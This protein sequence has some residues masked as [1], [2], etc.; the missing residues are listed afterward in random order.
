MS[1]EKQNWIDHLEDA[2]TGELLQEG[3]LITAN[4]MNHIEEG[5]Y[6][7]SSQ[8]KENKTFIT[9]EMF[10]GDTDN[11]KVQNAI[12]YAIA[13][14]VLLTSKGEKVYEISNTLVINGFIKIDFNMATLKATTNS[15]ILEINTTNTSNRY[16]GYIKNITFDCNNISNCAMKLTHSQRF[17]ISNIS[18]NKIKQTGIDIV[19]G[20]V[21]KFEYIWIYNDNDNKGTTGIINRAADMV[22]SHID[23]INVERSIYHT[24]G[25]AF[26][27]EVHGFVTDKVYENSV[28]FENDGTSGVFLDRCYPDT[29]QIFYKINN[30]SKMQITNNYGFW[31][32]QFMSDTLIDSYGNPY[33][34]YFK[35][36]N[37]EFSKRIAFNN[38]VI[39]GYGTDTKMTKFSN[40]SNSLIHMNATNLY[41][42]IENLRC[43]SVG[44][45]EMKTPF[46]AT[47]NYYEMGSESFRIFIETTFNPSINGKLERTGGVDIAYMPSSYTSIYQGEY[48]FPVEYGIG[49]NQAFKSLG[50]IPGALVKGSSIIRVKA[51][52]DMYSNSEILCDAN[53]NTNYTFRISTVLPTFGY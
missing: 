13:N 11:I 14:D 39:I 6:Q 43:S 38:N 30:I 45:L 34:F 2:E 35:D 26:Y 24:G 33:V 15:P 40:L 8:I 51:P 10:N 44:T 32:K 48:S 49:N 17:H 50:F 36:G 18:I 23:M 9:P 31:N 16:K 21:N 52:S 4:R 29:Q 3:T 7:A 20:N 37:I 47:V 41:E 12:N 22:F 1:Y 25:N 42:S 46:V 53:N 27:S 19:A 28:F 5:I